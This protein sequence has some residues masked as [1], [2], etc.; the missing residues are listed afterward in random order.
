MK[1]VLLADDDAVILK[2][3][4]TAL[5]R[6]GFQVT[7]ASDG[8]RATQT[9]LASKPDI[10]V[11]DLMMPGFNGVDVL[12]F[13][14]SKDAL[15]DLPVI[16]LTNAYLTD[17]A[18]K[19]IAIGVQ[20][21]ILK[22]RCSPSVLEKTINQLT[23]PGAATVTVP[24]R[25]HPAP[26][27]PEPE[28]R[29]QPRILQPPSKPD[30]LPSA[31]EAKST[32]EVHATVRTN[33]LKGA[34]KIHSELHMLYQEV[35]RAQNETD[36][37]MRLRNLYRRVHFL[38]ASAGM[39][40]CNHLALLASAFE[41]LLFEMM[42]R[43][44]LINPSTRVTVA[45]AVDFLGQLLDRAQEIEIART[46]VPRVLVVD[47]DPLSNRLVTSALQ[48]DL[49]SA[50]STEDPQAALEMARK[51]HYDLF[52]LDIEMPGMDGFELCKNIRVM[53]QYQHTPVIFVTSHSDFEHRAKSIL[54]G[55]NDLI[56]KPVVPI[57]LAVKAV[58]HLLRAQLMKSPAAK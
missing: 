36:R 40:E 39:A 27:P 4:E 56:S 9:L 26:P 34:A 50:R 54:S 12:K 41:A 24:P 37:D 44:E 7:T 25:V 51:G 5:T 18:D 10:L 29:P 45:M 23:E 52:L 47:D 35:V 55:S 13:V 17:L 28:P 30:E 2:L 46:N 42:H 58:T 53:P 15:R 33:L 3:Y 1:H 14:R 38:A 20:D 21:A 48:R 8:I 31:P 16:I 32:E 19:A 57:E 22:V 11:L 6:L 43:P 49:L